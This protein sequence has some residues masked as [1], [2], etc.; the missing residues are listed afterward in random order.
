[1]HFAPELRERL[2]KGAGSI[3]DKLKAARGFQVGQRLAR[4]AEAAGR[5][6]SKVFGDWLAQHPWLEKFSSPDR[7]A[8]LWCLEP[9]AW[10]DALKVIQRLDDKQ[11][12]SLG[13]RGLKSAVL[14][15]RGEAKPRATTAKPEPANAEPT[16]REQASQASN[17]T[18]A[19]HDATIAAAVE[20]ATAALKQA[21]VAEIEALKDVHAVEIAE[22]KD[23][24]LRELEAQFRRGEAQ[25][26]RARAHFNAKEVGTKLSVFTRSEINLL[27]KALHPDG[28]PREFVAMFTQASAL[29]NDRVELLVKAAERHRSKM[30]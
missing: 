1:L 28:K 23:A 25:G 2:I 29:F 26:A 8:A 3:L 11:R 6:Y 15:A 24:H 21:H 30:H 14:E 16:K 17:A 7:A 27:R 13:L 18:S 19:A 5:R 10:P 22:L 9:G 20:R 12:Q 4:E